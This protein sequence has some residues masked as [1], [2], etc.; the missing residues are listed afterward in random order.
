MKTC[1]ACNV[2]FHD[3]V[4]CGSCKK[5]LDFG[6][7]NISESGWRKL[8]SARMAQ[9]KCP[10]CRS[11]SPAVS[12]PEP[13]SL[14][15]ILG[16][17]RDMKRQLLNLPAL[18]EDIRAIRDELA[19]LKIS[20]ERAG[21]RLDE[22]ESRL[23]EVEEKV[24][25]VDNLHETVNRL[26]TDLSSTKFLQSSNEQRSR[27]N[28]VEI[29]GVPVKKDENLFSI[30]EAIGK[31]INYNCPK[32]QVNY[33][34]RVPIF[35]SNE[36]LIIVSFLNRYVKE[37]FVAAARANKDLSTSDIGFQGSSQRVYVNDHLSI[38]Y[39]KLLSKV[40]LTAKDK[41]YEYVWVKHS[42]IHVLKNKYS[43]VIIIRKDSDL[44]KLI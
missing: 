25:K 8:G 20:C 21:G 29:K 41:Q 28:N 18:V 3:G 9:W 33:I 43:K 5:H 16:E 22:F 37:D 36:K 6:C 35:N 40:K 10:M 19:G 38:E 1:A 32:S 2:Q 24:S 12:T 4:Q 14:D 34:S 15:T 31:R 7:A 44:N 39:K 11:S 42:K 13:T 26:Q 27:L 17:I 30:F 23:T